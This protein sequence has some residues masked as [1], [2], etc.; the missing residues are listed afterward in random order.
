MPTFLIRL[1]AVNFETS[2]YDTN[3]ISTIR[4]GSM[5][6]SNA[7]ELVRPQLPGEL[8]HAPVSYGDSHALW[9]FTVEDHDGA[10]RV[11]V[12]TLRALAEHKLLRH[13][14]FVCAV[15]LK[16][17]GG[18]REIQQLRMLN[19]W[20]QLQQPTVTAPD[21]P[22]AATRDDWKPYCELDRVRPSVATISKGK[23]NYRVSA[24]TKARREHGKT[25]KQ[26]FH[27]SLINEEV[28]LVN[29]LDELTSHPDSNHRLTG[30]MAIVYIDGNKQSEMAAQRG[31]A[32]LGKFR[33]YVRDK[34]CEFLTALLQDLAKT[35]PDAGKSSEWYFWDEQ[36]EEHEVRL[37]TLLWGGDDIILVVPAWQGWSVVRQFYQHASEWQFEEHEFTHATGVVFCSCKSPIR[38]VRQLAE[39]LLILAKKDC[40]QGN[41]QNRIAYEVLESF[42]A[43]HVDLECWRAAKLCPMSSNRDGTEEELLLTLEQM[44]GV[45]EMIRAVRDAVAAPDVDISRRQIE[46]RARSMSRCP[47]NDTEFDPNI[48]QYFYQIPAFAHVRDL[49]SRQKLFHL[50]ALWDYMT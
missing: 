10:E 1:E 28:A 45:Q 3:D 4:G 32:D 38:D 39:R 24:S 33:A 27:R 20:S 47:I 16:H 26:E 6:L 36:Q 44:R 46:S 40:N 37:E 7:H 31:I 49:S 35:R 22:E 41:Y 21:L 11:R 30:K 29:E 42:D 19:H 12:A 50:T 8:Q 13:A 25:Q 48:E 23:E 18:A 17:D 9:E 43:A 14:T 2:C 34:H 5:M 15:I